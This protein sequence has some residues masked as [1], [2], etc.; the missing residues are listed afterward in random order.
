[1]SASFCITL[2]LFLF[3]AFPFACLL[4]ADASLSAPPV[5]T[6]NW[7]GADSFF[8]YALNES[9]RVEHLA[10]MQAADMKVVRLFLSG[11]GR[12]AKGSSARSIPDVE[13][14][15]LGVWDDR[16]LESVDQLMYEALSYGVK[17]DISL[18]DRYS[19]GCWAEDAYYREFHFPSGQVNG[20]CDAQKNDVTSFYVNS[21][22][23]AVFDN[24]LVHILTHRNALL[25]NRSWGQLPEVVFT[26]AAENEAQS[27]QRS[28]DWQWNCRRA[29]VMRQY[30]H[31]GILI[32]TNGAT[33]EDSLQEE[34]FRCPEL[35]LLAVHNYGGGRDFAANYS[36]RARELAVK[37]GKRVYVE[38]FGALGDNDGSKAVGLQQQIDGILSAHVPFMFWELL[39]TQ[40]RLTDFETWT[41]CKAW[42]L[43]SNRS[44]QAAADT[45]GAFAWPELYGKE[46]AAAVERLRISTSQQQHRHRRGTV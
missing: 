30:L 29:K 31:P 45:E 27:F 33:V 41:G 10:A 23:Q 24:R 12:G 9:D 34:L 46:P 25:G 11:I 40:P 28:R 3:A 26:V 4:G 35:D 32:S 22:I 36:S 37:Y 38:E 43:L 42:D 8:L 13:P 44:Q 19:L 16:I 18:H 1:M 17:L 5:V 2:L 15:T 6:R 7:A 39:K 14:E 21:S 20:S